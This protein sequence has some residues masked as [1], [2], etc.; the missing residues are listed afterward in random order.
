MSVLRPTGKR[1]G[2]LDGALTDYDQAIKLNPKYT[3]ACNNRGNIKF[4]KGDPDGAMA[5]FNQAMKLKRSRANTCPKRMQS[6]EDTGLRTR[7]ENDYG[8]E[9]QADQCC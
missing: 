2:D 7:Q 3:F 1:R 6:R 4:S 8:R 5:D 9:S